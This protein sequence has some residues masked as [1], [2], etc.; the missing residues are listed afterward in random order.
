MTV[1]LAII[2]RLE[3]LEALVAAQDRQI[4]SLLGRGP[5]AAGQ[6]ELY[7]VVTAA[8]PGLG[9]YPATGNTFGIIFVDR[10]FTAL[11]GDRSVTEHPRSGL[12]MAIARTVNGSYLAEGRNAVAF[13]APPPPGTTGKGKWWLLPPQQEGILTGVLYEELLA[14]QFAQVDEI[15]FNPANA[16]VYTGRRHVVWDLKMSD[17]DSLPAETIIDYCLNAAGDR[18]KWLTAFCETADNL[19]NIESPQSPGDSE[20]EASQAGFSPGDFDFLPEN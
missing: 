11:P 16:R 20:S 17:D 10:E 18:Y 15:D 8:F 14:G 7:H 4:Q 2:R 19:D 9:P 12:G 5:H 13:H 6:R 1:P 3:Q